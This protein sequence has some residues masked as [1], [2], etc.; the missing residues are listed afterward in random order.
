MTRYSLFNNKLPFTRI[1]SLKSSLAENRSYHESLLSAARISRQRVPWLRSKLTVIGRGRAGKTSTVRSLLNRPFNP[2]WTSTVGAD[3]LLVKASRMNQSKPWEEVKAIQTSNV[4]VQRLAL[5]LLEDRSTSVVHAGIS[6]SDATIS[7]SRKQLNDSKDKQ[8]GRREGEERSERRQALY[9]SRT[10]FA[11][12]RDELETVRLQ[13]IDLGGQEVYRVTHDLFL[14]RFGVYVYVFDLTDMGTVD[15]TNAVLEDFTFW[16]ASISFYTSNAQLCIVATHADGVRNTLEAAKPLL[17]AVSRK[18]SE[19]GIRL[20]RN[21]RG[22]PL[23]LVDNKSGNGVDAL[24]LAL[25]QAM[26]EEDYMNEEVPPQWGYALE[27]IHAKGMWV[28]RSI[29]REVCDAF[30]IAEMGEMLGF[31]HDMGLV[32]YNRSSEVLKAVV[33]TNLSWLVQAFAAVIHDERVH[34]ICDSAGEVG[35]EHDADLLYKRGIVSRDLLEFLWDRT[36]VDFLIHLLQELL[37][38]SQWRFMSGSP[39]DLYLIPSMLPQMATGF[40][41]AAEGWTFRLDFSY[42]PEGVFERV[43]CHIVNHASGALEPPVLCKGAGRIAVGTNATV[44]LRRE[45]YRIVV[46]V[47]DA[48]HAGLYLN[49]I[50]SVIKHIQQRVSSRSLTYHVTVQMPGGE[51]IAF[52]QAVRAKVEPWTAVGLRNRENRVEVD[53]VKAFMDI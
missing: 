20:I 38:V 2:E 39:S 19:S 53:L 28:E 5:K 16:I 51:F 7:K 14:T 3:T 50:Q 32:Y 47:S 6:M 31:F 4:L 23:F 21:D 17:K 44:R 10:V 33:T 18:W 52:D 41:N 24:R 13:V 48:Q 49:M 29:V 27:A 46:T 40:E 1:K 45:L 43:M 15:K 36:Q 11:E 8:A 30:G 26:K 37:L 9:E 25:Y 12:A 22:N 35:L 42:L 34:S